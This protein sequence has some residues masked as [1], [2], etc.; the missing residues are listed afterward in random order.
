MRENDAARE[1]TELSAFIHSPLTVLKEAIIATVAR[2]RKSFCQNAE[3]S[4][5]F[6]AL[7]IRLI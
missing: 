4:E 5:V 1:E 3:L 2:K 6:F 7:T